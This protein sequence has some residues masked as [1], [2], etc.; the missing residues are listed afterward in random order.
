MVYAVLIPAN[1]SS[2][3][4]AVINQLPVHAGI[5]STCSSSLVGRS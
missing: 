1:T 2:T 3:L 5:L 4:L